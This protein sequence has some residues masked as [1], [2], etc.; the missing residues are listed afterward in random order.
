VIKGLDEPYGGLFGISTAT[1]RGALA[2]TMR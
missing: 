2:D 1:K